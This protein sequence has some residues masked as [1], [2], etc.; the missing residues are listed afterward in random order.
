[1]ND[2]LQTTLVFLRQNDQVLLA[3]KKR[4]HGAAK[5]NGVGGKIEPGET[6]EQAARRECREEINIDPLTIAKMGLLH[7]HQEPPIDTY[8]NQDS[9]VF[10][11]D[12]WQG[13][14]KE[15]DEMAPRWFDVTDIPYDN[16]WS[17]DIYWLPLLLDN[18]TFE[19]D[20]YFDQDNTLLHHEVTT[21]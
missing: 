18:R 4:G 15:S 8:S 20:F 11:C 9:H 10:V 17:D 16:M 19:G 2:R 1:M 7:F 14:P 21:S 3:S 6:P 5:W 13:E 12:T